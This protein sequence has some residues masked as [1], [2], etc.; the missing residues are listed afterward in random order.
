[1]KILFSFVIILFLSNLAIAQIIS[2]T[3]TD[4]SG[5]PLP[6]VSVYIKGTSQG[7]VSNEKG[8]YQFR[9]KAGDVIIVYQ[10]IGYSTEERPLT[11]RSNAR[12]SQNIVLNAS[13]VNLNEFVVV[14]SGRNFARDMIR[15]VQDKRR[16]F[17]KSTAEYS[18]LDYC[19]STILRNY[20]RNYWQDTIIITK[21]S[22]DRKRE[23]RKAER[24]KKRDEKRLSRGKGEK[25]K[26][27]TKKEKKR[28]YEDS[29]A[30]LKKDTLR[31]SDFN[32]RYVSS[33]IETYSCNFR[34]NHVLSQSQVLAY[35]EP[36]INYPGY[37]LSLTYGYVGGG[38]DIDNFQGDNS[39]PNIMIDERE[40]SQLNIY[41]PN[42]YF[43]ELTEKPIA[44]PLGANA[45]VNYKFRL[46]GSSFKYGRKS[47]IINFTPLFPG[48]PLWEGSMIIADSTFSVL[49]FK[50]IIPENVLLLSDS[51]SIEQRYKELDSNT[52]IPVYTKLYYSVKEGHSITDVSTVSCSDSISFSRSKPEMKYNQ[53]RM[54]DEQ[55]DFRDSAYWNKHRAIPLSKSESDFTDLVDSLN[56]Y[57]TR[58]PFL[59]RL[60]STYNRLNIWNFLIIGI[61]HRDRY[62][63]YEYRISPLSEQ[64]NFFGIGGYRH[65]L[66]VNFQKVLK[67]EMLVETETEGNYGFTNNDLKGRLGLGLTY[68]PQKFVRTFIR[69]GDYYSFINP[70]ASITQFVSRSNFARRQVFSVSQ[71]MEVFNGFFSEMTLNYTRQRPINNLNIEGWS[72]TL[73]GELNRPVDFSEYIKAE[74]MLELKYRHNQKYYIKGKRKYILGSKWP[75]LSLTYRKGFPRIFN[76]EVNFDYLEIGVKDEIKKGPFGNLRYEISAGSFINKSNLRL[77][78]YKYFRGSDKFFFSDPLMSF[79]LLGPTLNT[80]D[81]FIRGN[82]IN[83]FQ[84]FLINK[85]PLLHRL[86]L[87]FAGGAGFMLMKENSFRHAEVFFG[88]E[89]I[90]R[91]RRQLIRLGVYAVTSDNSVEKAVFTWKV[92]ISFFDS[93]NNKWS[94]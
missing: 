40:L 14:S 59:T 61:Q 70:N 9:L 93:F 91:I 39:N 42:I 58:K 17:Y 64:M 10:I 86:R 38:L 81:A 66:S 19:K 3:V 76:S 5:V 35:Q 43:P 27:E 15:K 47:F 74:I 82:F 32:K 92:G 48:E 46:G 22:I 52:S 49:E 77:L 34:D 69:F 2:G 33:Y 30:A 68:Y 29:L 24:Q 50:A 56:E 57:F 85:I 28:K 31:S 36:K 63:K 67:N 88:P 75:E 94:Y 6:G 37:Y 11:I 78:E 84:G 79:Q 12:V 53:V 8:F 62:K 7:S 45:L 41:A 51:F 13:N 25:K 71:R 87:S 72:N 16:V 89:R 44:S 83:H 26:K 54:Y 60:D 18:S 23:I 80:S 55:S 4:S 21:D 65:T 1:M 20:T 90:I 73:F